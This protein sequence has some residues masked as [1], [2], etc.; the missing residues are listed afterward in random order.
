V[1]GNLSVGGNFTVNGT[2]TV[3]GLTRVAGSTTLGFSSV[4]TL[5]D[6]ETTAF[7]NQKPGVSLGGIRP[8][9]ANVS[10]S[11]AVNADMTASHVRHDSL[12]VGESITQVTLTIRESDPNF[13]LA[14]VSQVRSLDLYPDPGNPGDANYVT[15]T[16]DL[17]NNALIVKYSGASSPLNDIT[18][19]VRVARGD[20]SWRDP[21][22]NGLTP[23]LN[24]SI[25]DPMYQAVGVLD[26]FDQGYTEFPVGGL[27]VDANVVIVKAT[28]GGDADL[29]GDVTFLDYG[30]I[31]FA[32][33]SNNP[34]SGP[35][36]EVLLTGWR[37]G[38]FDYDGAITFL[39][40]GFINFVYAT[41]YPEGGGVSGAAGAVP[42]PTTMVLLG[43]GL[44][45]LLG[46]GR[47][48]LGAD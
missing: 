16:V 29:D 4:P 40:Y 23:G 35:P 21:N 17:T 27:P 6:V 36:P 31:N 25:I 44:I 48:S 37:N 45:G 15:S 5:N 46:R 12:K 14:G 39:D 30:A 19:M 2:A 32:Y 10:S 42:E 7:V 11:T 9:D 38:D 33:A 28:W 26:N 24:S 8:Y 13:P 18:A 41:L 34:E 47:R 43:L 3:G 1:D 22:T 20:G